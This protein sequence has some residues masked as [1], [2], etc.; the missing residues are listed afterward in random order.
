M[1]ERNLEKSFIPKSG[2]AKKSSV[3]L[4]GIVGGGVF[5]IVLL[6]ALGVF[7]YGQYLENAN[8]EIERQI[9][10]EADQIDEEVLAELKAFDARLN[11]VEDL[12]DNHI[13]SSH[14]LNLIG[15]TTVTSIRF[16]SLEFNTGG[17]YPT[18]SI[19]GV[20][21]DF[22]SV[23]AQVGILRANEE[24]IKT[25]ISE[26]SIEE[27]E[28][29]GDVLFTIDAQIRPDV[30][31]YIAFQEDNEEELDEDD[32]DVDDTATTTPEGDDD[33]TQN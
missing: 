27:D 25:L 21:P 23:A 11:S 19:S 14:L 24:F 16:D 12:M 7:L 4:S 18:V 6:I 9:S 8:A 17:S 10:E 1:A 13:A 28:Q 30:I 2:G 33:N 3:S 32:E 31:E 20:S 15:E 22:R 29:G 26:L 5:V